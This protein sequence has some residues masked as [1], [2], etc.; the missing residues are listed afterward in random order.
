MKKIKYSYQEEGPRGCNKVMLYSNEQI[1]SLQFGPGNPGPSW[2]I[3]A[4]TLKIKT[5]VFA[6]KLSDVVFILLINI[7][8]PTIS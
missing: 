1:C 7:E 5:F 8:M 3:K 6:F 2:L 4:K